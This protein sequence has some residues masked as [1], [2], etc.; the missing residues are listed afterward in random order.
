MH[1]S[2][3][4]GLINGVVQGSGI[5]PVMFFIYVNELIDILEAFWV[6]VNMLAD[7]AKM[8][9]RGCS[10]VVVE[11]WIRDSEGAGSTLARSV[12]CKQSW[13]SC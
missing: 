5:G 11:Y 9:L 7:D 6:K 10:G 8:Y 13:A 4:A 2:D 1:V 12:H 3:V